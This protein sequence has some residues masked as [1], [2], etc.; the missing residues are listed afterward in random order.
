[1]INTVRE[2]AKIIIEAANNFERGAGLN[3]VLIISSAKNVIDMLDTAEV[4]ME[5]VSEYADYCCDCGTNI[6]RYSK[7]WGPL[8]P[9]KD[10][11][12]LFIYDPI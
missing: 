4:I 3:L 12:G 9:S 11:R 10:V 1:M 7:Y 6:T 2:S 5:P 8:D